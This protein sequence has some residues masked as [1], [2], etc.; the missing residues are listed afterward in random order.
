MKLM[1]IPKWIMTSCKRKSV[2]NNCIVSITGDIY[3][4]DILRKKR[5]C[6]YEVCEWFNFIIFLMFV[7][8][9]TSCAIIYCTNQHSYN[10]AN[11]VMDFICSWILHIEA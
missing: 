4:S 1:K 6:D 10:H 11:E 9:A 7:L 2:P 8:C 5:R 3:V